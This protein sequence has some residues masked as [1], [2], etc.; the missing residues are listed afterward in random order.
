[1]IRALACDID[2]TLTDERRRLSPDALRLIREIEEL[3]VPVVLATGNILCVTE[4]AK[5][6]IGTSGPVIAENGGVIKAPGEPGPRYFCDVKS[7]EISRAYEHLSSLLDVRLTNGSEL[8]K[9]EIAIYRDHP[10]EEV[11]SVL[12][13]FNVQI[14]DTK[15][16]I[17]LMD[18]A[19]NKGRALLDVAEIMGIDIWEFAAIGDS[20][21]DREMLELSGLGI[22]VGDSRLKNSADHLIREGFAEGGVKALKKVISRLEKV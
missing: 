19:V 14:V 18:P 9:T 17:H 13:D 10:V 20:E 4:A 12:A 3:G 5:T 15:F 8:R 22:A 16:A 1:M 6:F 21:N 7:G 2:G 11:K